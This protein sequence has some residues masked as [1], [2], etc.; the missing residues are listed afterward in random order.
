M[1]KINVWL[2]CS[3]FLHLLL[4]CCFPFGDELIPLSVNHWAK[5]KYVDTESLPSISIFAVGGS[6]STSVVFGDYGHAFI[7]VVN[8]SPSAIIVG[9][10][11]LGVNEGVTLGTWDRPN[12]HVG[13]WHNLESY[14]YS[15][16]GLFG[17]RDSLSLTLTATRLAALNSYI[18]SHDSWT[19]T[20]NCS[21]FACG[22]W[23]CSEDVILGAGVINTPTNLKN[24]IQTHS[25]SINASLPSNSCVGYY[26][27]NNYVASHAEY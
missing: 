23:N 2:R 7:S 25:Y 17:G 20:S 9:N 21:T 1:R 15:T 3:S 16:N 18:L 6:S 5:R 12:Y 27:N 13:L 10:M 22:A 26:S 19:E 11:Q 14:L 4:F 24:D 8:S